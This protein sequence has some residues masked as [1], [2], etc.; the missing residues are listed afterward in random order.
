MA[1]DELSITCRRVER[2]LHASEACTLA[3]SLRRLSLVLEGNSTLQ[4]LSID[5]IEGVV[6]A[7]PQLQPRSGSAGSSFQNDETIIIVAVAPEPDVVLLVSPSNPEGVENSSAMQSTSE[8]IWLYIRQMK[9]RRA[10]KGNNPVKAIFYRL[11]EPLADLLKADS[12]QGYIKWARGDS[13]LS[14]IPFQHTRLDFLKFHRNRS[15]MTKLSGHGDTSIE[16]SCDDVRAVGHL[17]PYPVGTPIDDL[18][19]MNNTGIVFNLLQSDAAVEKLVLIVSD[20]ALYMTKSTG[21]IVCRIAFSS[22][23]QHRLVQSATP[24]DASLP[25]Q[26]GQD[27]RR[28]LSSGGASVVVLLYR[29]D[30][31]PDAGGNPTRKVDAIAIT[32]KYAPDIFNRLRV[33]KTTDPFSAASDNDGDRS[34]SA[35]VHELAPAVEL[36]SVSV[37]AEASMSNANTMTASSR[38]VEDDVYPLLALVDPSVSDHQAASVYV[39]G[40][41][42]VSL[43]DQLRE[44]D[45]TIRLLQQRCSIQ[46]QAKDGSVNGAP[47]GGPAQLAL[48]PSQRAGKCATPRSKSP[49]PAV[50]NPTASSSTD[51]QRSKAP[52]A[53]STRDEELDSLRHYVTMLEAQLQR[54]S[55][56]D[57]ERRL[58][59]LEDSV[60]VQPDNDDQLSPA[61]CK[62]LRLALNEAIR[63]EALLKRHIHKLQ[64]EM[65]ELSSA[66]NRA[67]TE[68]SD[69]VTHSISD[70]V[71]NFERHREVETE[72]EGIV[73]RLLE[74]LE[75]REISV[76]QEVTARLAEAQS[77]NSSLVR[78]LRERD[79]LL[80]RLSQI[81][82]LESNDAASGQQQQNARA[83][84]RQ[85]VAELYERR[86]NLDHTVRSLVRQVD[87]LQR[88]RGNLVDELNAVASRTAH[89]HHETERELHV[90]RHQVAV[91]QSLQSVPLVTNRLASLE[92]LALQAT[93]QKREALTSQMEREAAVKDLASLR[94][95]LES[96][97]KEIGKLRQKIV[98]CDKERMDLIRERDTLQ[99]RL[100]VTSDEVEKKEKEFKKTIR[101][102]QNRVHDLVQNRKKQ[103]GQASLMELADG[104]NTPRTAAATPRQPSSDQICSPRSTPAASPP[105]SAVSR[106]QQLEDALRAIQKA[107]PE[108]SASPQP[109]PLSSE[110]AA[111]ANNYS[112]N[113]RGV[114]PEIH[115]YN[116]KPRDDYLQEKQHRDTNAGA[117]GATSTDVKWHDA[118]DQQ[119]RNFEQR[120]KDLEVAYQP[121]SQRHHHAADALADH[122]MGVIRAT[123]T[124]HATD[125]LHAQELEIAK[126]KAENT[127]LRHSSPAP[128][129]LQPSLRL[130]KSTSPSAG[131][132]TSGGR[133]SVSATRRSTS[134]QL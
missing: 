15:V 47:A 6:I 76:Q 33:P 90:L 111:A 96:A 8:H 10:A 100:S 88:S 29:P 122:H 51:H 3:L 32:T 46:Q 95:Q 113:N 43:A 81:A 115:N 23:I 59:E 62:S 7:A 99:Q 36:R 41:R 130:K 35:A 54:T 97:H 89:D 131:R 72:G 102:Q 11:E 75:R 98:G 92:L 57:T 123:P 44:R 78:E 39:L 94:N 118:F 22:I 14:V 82:G 26:Q 58:H 21:A 79:A 18:R 83:G 87:D 120:L 42:I 84:F 126:L 28:G 91:L 114:Q 110:L 65:S 124:K 116:A 20:R 127:L 37:Q 80:E 17:F 55:D 117:E 112:H 119:R 71:V 125:V 132:S 45:V 30:A 70:F 53:S 105:P 73:R 25:Q 93:N 134:R 103:S 34:P 106:V 40:Q 104:S 16:V 4:C 24:N 85:S 69:R 66:T 107:R 108:W 129:R 50:K 19:N 12:A 61:A 121:Q 38:V 13:S 56:A 86:N 68:M 9:E 63:N 52:A 128:G 48:Q 74:G 49:G 64:M 2:D 1:D 27:R 77:M 101:Y 5:Q 31:L 133:D 60:L 67:L 109:N